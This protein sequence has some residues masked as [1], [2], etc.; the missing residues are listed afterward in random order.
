MIG[1]LARQYSN[2][3]QGGSLEALS[4]QDFA[5]ILTDEQE[6][7]KAQPMSKLLPSSSRAVFTACTRLAS[8]T[9]KTKKPA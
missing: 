1:V 5:P 7:P 6:I 2:W 9:T 3:G 4:D 8:K